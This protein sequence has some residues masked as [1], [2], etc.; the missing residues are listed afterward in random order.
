M[1]WKAQ[2][3][4]LHLLIEA[5]LLIQLSR[6]KSFGQL[7]TLI[8]DPSIYVS[9]VSPPASIVIWSLELLP[10]TVKIRNYNTWEVRR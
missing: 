10:L 4:S 9:N 2:I 6:Q 1:E 5:Y 7:S 8:P 3:L